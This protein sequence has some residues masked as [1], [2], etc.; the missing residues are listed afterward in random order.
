MIILTCANSEFRRWEHV[1]LRD[2]SFRSVIEATARQAE[3]CG[4][5]TAIFDLGTL[6]LGEKYII[7]DEHFSSKGYY[8]KEPIPG[9]K[10]KSLFKPELV[11]IVM[12]R[13]NDIVAYLDGD[14]QLVGCIDEIV[15]DDYDI[16]VTLRPKW[17]T[18]TEWNKANFNIVKYINAGVIFFNPTK[19]AKTFVEEWKRLTDEVGND[20]M[21][22]NQL[23]CP[24]FYPAAFSVETVNGVRIKYFPCERYNFYFFGQIFASEAKIFHFKGSIRKFFP[25]RWEK[26]IFCWMRAL[27]VR[28]FRSR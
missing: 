13:H 22:L 10:S 14:A 6:G 25:F 15:G 21:A 8:E 20:Q 9:Y 26:Q 5:T 3:K 1:E 23:A 4:Y 2:F 27:L 7:E 28:L 24:D 17:E 12:E 18:E 11:Q 16:G 19:A